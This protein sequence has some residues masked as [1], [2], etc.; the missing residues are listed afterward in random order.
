MSFV[1]VPSE[2]L[3]ARLRAAG[4]VEQDYPRDRQS[5]EVVF[6]R[7]HDRDSR[8]RILVYTS[9]RRGSF[10]ARGKGA[11]AIRV[12]AIYLEGFTSRGVAKLPRVHRTGTVED[13]L[14][15]VIDRARRAYAVCNERIRERSR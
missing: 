7:K 11:D 13:V 6:E 3:F 1:E 8:Y 10:T 15:R 14:E 2:R 12:C 5:G 9:V 4:F